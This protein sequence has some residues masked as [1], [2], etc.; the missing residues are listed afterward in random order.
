MTTAWDEYVAAAQ[1]LDSV[2][3]R[4]AAI[5]AEESNVQRAAREDLAAVRRR[6]ALQQSRF[7]E[8]ASRYGV[9][10]PALAPG[11][12]DGNAALV[13]GSGPT[14][15][16]TALHHA[17]STLDNADAELT[18]VDS[19]G[20]RAARLADRPAAV[21]NLVVYGAFAL[22]VLVLQGI[23]FAVASEESLPAL[24]PIC[25]LVLPLLAFGLGWLTVGLVYPPASRGGAIDRTPLVGAVVCLVAPVLLTCAGFGVFALLR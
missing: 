3:R 6:M 4:A 1:R 18:A 19:P 10:A 8:L 23:L 11:D 20:V 9:R 13:P 17:R 25:G 14:A 12:A 7:A 2:R 16:L 24:A 21:R 5:A 15:V 22:L